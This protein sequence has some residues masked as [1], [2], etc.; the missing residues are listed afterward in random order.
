MINS[1]QWGTRPRLQKASPYWKWEKRKGGQEPVT[2]K[3][4]V[5][6][7]GWRS[8]SFRNQACNT[9]IPENMTK[10]LARTY[11]AHSDYDL[12]ITQNSA[13][14]VSKLPP[15][16][17]TAWLWRERKAPGG[18]RRPPRAELEL[19]RTEGGFWEKVRYMSEQVTWW[20]APRARVCKGKAN[21]DRPLIF[22][23]R[24]LES[25]IL[26]LFWNFFLATFSL[27]I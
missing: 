7:K 14:P 20:L 18:H 27:L 9:W 2:W 11:N 25:R 3:E 13:L 12:K 26:E 21:G 24:G 15:A 17:G 19:L 5:K 16:E 6:N 1:E 22:V 23:N 8:I 10:F 4:H